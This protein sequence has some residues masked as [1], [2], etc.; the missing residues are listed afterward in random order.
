MHRRH[1][2]QRTGKVTKQCGIY[3]TGIVSLRLRTLN[4][5]DDV[6]AARQ[7]IER[8]SC[9]C[10]SDALVDFFIHPQHRIPAT[11]GYRG[12]GGRGFRLLP[13]S[14]RRCYPHRQP[15]ACPHRQPAASAVPG[16][17]IAGV[18]LASAHLAASGSTV[19]A[20]GQRLCEVD[21]GSVRDGAAKGQGGDT[22][23]NAHAPW[24]T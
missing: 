19:E 2:R 11:P 1:C 24:R 12:G 10:A 9:A 16:A 3:T 14:R 21:P 17:C 13:R 7:S 6:R 4:G 8:S 23:G 22:I 20:A 15:N 18:A 5:M